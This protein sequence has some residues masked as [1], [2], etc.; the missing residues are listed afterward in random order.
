MVG[1]LGSLLGAVL[2]GFLIGIVA[3]LLQLLLPLL[4]GTP[5]P[6]ADERFVLGQVRYPSKIVGQSLQLDDLKLVHVE[7][8]RA[9]KRDV[10]ELYDLTRDPAERRNRAREQE[11]D[12]RR[13]RRRRRARRSPDRRGR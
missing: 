9:G 4:L 1:G 7:H 8:D 6:H 10:W 3:V 11:A 2:G 12:T 5:D 13:L